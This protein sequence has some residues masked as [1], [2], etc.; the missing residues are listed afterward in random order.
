MRPTRCALSAPSRY[1]QPGVEQCASF[2][3]QEEAMRFIGSERM[4][5]TARAVGVSKEFSID[6]QNR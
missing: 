6:A 2:P 1:R 5:R 4:G 3:P